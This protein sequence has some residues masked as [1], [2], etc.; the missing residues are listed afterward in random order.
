MAKLTDLL[1]EAKLASM[2]TAEPVPPDSCLITPTAF[3]LKVSILTLDKRERENICCGTALQEGCAN[4]QTALPDLS[5]LSAG[6]ALHSGNAG[7]ALHFSVKHT[8]L[9]FCV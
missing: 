5:P 8:E 9:H 4:C 3:S 2:L 7:T 1:A 6:T